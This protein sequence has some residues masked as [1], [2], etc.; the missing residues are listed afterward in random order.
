MDKYIT[1]NNLDEMK[2]GQEKEWFLSKPIKDK[3]DILDYLKG[4]GVLKACGPDYFED[5]VTGKRIEMSPNA[6]TD[7]VYVW[8]LDELYH[9]EHYNLKLNDDFIEYVLAKTKEGKR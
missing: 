3:E 4:K 9:F 5:K 1:S 2:N 8:Y 6:Y 7:G